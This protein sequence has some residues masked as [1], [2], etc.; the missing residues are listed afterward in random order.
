[1]VAYLD[2][3]SAFVGYVGAVAINLSM[4]GSLDNFDPAISYFKSLL[5]NN[6][7]VPKQS[8]YARVVS[9]EIPILMDFD[10]NAYRAKYS[11][12]G[13]FEFVI[14]C[15]GS[16]SVPYVVSMIKGAP[17]KQNAEKIIDYLLSNKGQE[18]WAKAY[19]R[20]VREVPLPKEVKE[21]FLPDSDYARA[22]SIDYGKMEDVQKK[23]SDRYLAEV[24]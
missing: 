13:N 12:K 6:P 5:K 23:F 18:I 22:K 2:P 11:E 17:H 15:E 8:S 10:F 1:M 4:G 16:L 20:P 21:R 9:G 7:I 24:R 19:L 3:P 14:P